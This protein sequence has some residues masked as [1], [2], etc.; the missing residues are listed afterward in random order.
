MYSLDII[1]WSDWSVLSEF[2]LNLSLEEYKSLTDKSVNSI[3]LFILKRA[4][5]NFND[6]EEVTLS[7]KIKILH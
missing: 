1:K 4:W 6:W 5:D 3:V 2:S 7:Y